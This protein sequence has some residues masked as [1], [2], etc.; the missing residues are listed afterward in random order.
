MLSALVPRWFESN[1]PDFMTVSTLL[2]RVGRLSTYRIK[3]HAGSIP[4]TVAVMARYA[5]WQCGNFQKVVVMGSTPILA[6][7]N[8]KRSIK[9]SAANYP[10]K[11]SIRLVKEKIEKLNTKE[12]MPGYAKWKCGEA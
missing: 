10:V 12:Q 5:N 9:K 2:V 4:V 11:K 1:C 7:M 8:G 6:T 3:F